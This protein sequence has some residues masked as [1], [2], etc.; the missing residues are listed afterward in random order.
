MSRTGCRRE[1][2]G[3]TEGREEAVTALWWAIAVALGGLSIWLFQAGVGYLW[4]A[5][6]LLSGANSPAYASLA[7]RTLTAALI[8]ALL[9]VATVVMGVRSKRRDESRGL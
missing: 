4:A 3:N 5:D 8:A 7:V 1:S 6:R 2:Q 9:T